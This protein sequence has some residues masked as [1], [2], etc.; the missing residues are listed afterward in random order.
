MQISTRYLLGT[1]GGHSLVTRKLDLPTSSLL[2]GG[3]AFNVV[4]KADLSHI[5]RFREGNLH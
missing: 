1:D 4:V 5:M 2:G 3:L